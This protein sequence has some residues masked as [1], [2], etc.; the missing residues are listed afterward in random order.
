LGVA[1]RIA[2]AG[3]LRSRKHGQKMVLR[4]QKPFSK[5]SI[6]LLQT[7]I[8]WSDPED[9]LNSLLLHARESANDDIGYPKLFMA[10]EES[11]AKLSPQPAVNN[12]AGARA[13]DRIWM[14]FRI[15]FRY[16]IP[17]FPAPAG[18]V[19]ERKV[20]LTTFS[21]IDRPPGRA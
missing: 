20:A 2:G 18:Q 16:P 10:G 15:H 3:L 4:A 9:P 19:F 8:A 6:H 13:P 14:V 17:R 7:R 1:G 5:S 11:A 12:F 21:F